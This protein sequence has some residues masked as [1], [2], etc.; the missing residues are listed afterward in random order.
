MAAH[1]YTWELKYLA[2]PY[3]AWTVE[4]YADESQAME[5]F[6]ALWTGTPPALNLSM[7][8]IRRDLDRPER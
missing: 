1:D 5:A 3:Q 8:S 2:Y 7:R 6:E 4:E